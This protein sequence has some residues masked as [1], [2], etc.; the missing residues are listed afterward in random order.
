L[1]ND[2]LVERKEAIATVTF[3]RPEQRNAVS[4]A[5]W[6]RI[7]KLVL[8]L[9]A[10]NEVRAIVFRGAGR[11]AFVAGAD[12]SE[13]E[14]VRKDSKTAKAY[15]ALLD[16]AYRT[17]R[18]CPKPT[19]AMVFG[20]CMGGGMTLATSCDL[21]F[22]AEGSKFAIPAARLSIVYNIESTSPLVHIVG[23]SRAKDLLF[24]ARTLDSAEALALGLVNR[25]LPADE[26]EEFTYGYLKKVAANAPLTIQGAKAVI[27]AIMEHSPASAQSADQLVLD[28]FDSEDYRE[29]VRAFLEKRPPTFRGQ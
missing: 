4:V 14:E 25:V 24:S 23:P 17:I 27:A 10:D 7:P 6:E 16:E 12:I 20:Y 8:E 19:V 26:L 13:F 5:M 15:N 9:G 28:A 22:V 21:R 2:I 3:N 11:Q 1:S 18:H 29:A